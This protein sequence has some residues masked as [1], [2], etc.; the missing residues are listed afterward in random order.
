MKKLTRAASMLL[1]A[2][3]I[4]ASA[5]TAASAAIVKYPSGAKEY[6]VCEICDYLILSDEDYVYYKGGYYHTDCRDD[7]R[8]I[9]LAPTYEYVTTYV[10]VVEGGSVY[11]A[12]GK[13]LVG[14]RPVVTV[15]PSVKPGTVIKP[16]VSVI[17][18]GATIVGGKYY[19]LSEAKEYL[20]EYFEDNTYEINMKEGETRTIQ[21]GSYFFSSNPEVAYYDYKTGKIVAN[22][23]GAAE[24]YVCTNGGIPYFCLKVNVV[25]RFTT[26]AK[27]S[28]Y[29]QVTAEDYQL[30]VGE[31]TTIKAAASNG[32]T[33]DD[34]L[35][36]VD[37]GEDRATVGAKSGSFLADAN[38]PVVV[39]AYSKS[40]PNVKGEALLFIGNYKNYIYDGMWTLTENGI[41]VNGWGSAD[42]SVDYYSYIAGWVQSDEDG[43]L[44]PVVKKLDAISEDGEKTTIL[45]TDTVDYAEL[46]KE[47]YG[48]KSDLISI[49]KKYNLY[50]NGISENKVTIGDIDFGKL[51]LGQIFKSING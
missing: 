28:V 45:T 26:T 42:V 18:P 36:S 38:G 20:A 41:C 35:F 32:K 22:D 14:T 31:K 11:K 13:V 30:S 33:Y 2:L 21:A 47:A 5:A 39:R 19:S 37:F 4:T 24:I 10:P 12:G 34:I 7:D 15:K 27:Q 40:N 25:K 23:S 16:G 44:I 3:T 9:S 1:A 49:I 6:H 43:L 8:E 46:L 29:L 51:Y 48:N 50:K 17:K